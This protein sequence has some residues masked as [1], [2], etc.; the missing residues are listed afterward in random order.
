MLREEVEYDF[1]AAQ[2]F[3]EGRRKGIRCVIVV[4]DPRHGGLRE[5]SLACG[6]TKWQMIRRI[7]LPAAVPGIMTG[8][9]LAMSRA[10][11]A[12]LPNVPVTAPKSYFGT[13]GASGGAVEMA[14]S[15]SVASVSESVP[16]AT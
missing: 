13:L 12:C 11:D 6:S 1:E 15:C 4:A 9:I 5:G 16:S 3:V 10:I 2:V 7:V 14:A 8:S